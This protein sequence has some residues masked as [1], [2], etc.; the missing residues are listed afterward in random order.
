MSCAT[1]RVGASC[2]LFML[3]TGRV[4]IGVVGRPR[5]FPLNDDLNRS[6]PRMSS[7]GTCGLGGIR[8]SPRLAPMPEGSR[9]FCSGAR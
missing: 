4:V 9:C 2:M 8:R 1:V 5:V 7:C 6:L 3:S